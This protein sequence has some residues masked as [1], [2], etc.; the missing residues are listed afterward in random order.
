MVDS[1]S[2][3]NGISESDYAGAVIGIS[4]AFLFVSLACYFLVTR[5]NKAQKEIKPKDEGLVRTVSA[6]NDRAWDVAAIELQIEEI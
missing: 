5:H 4:A 2:K 3:S 1:K 6:R